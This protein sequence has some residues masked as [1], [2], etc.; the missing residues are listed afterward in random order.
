MEY[1]MLGRT[2][3]RV[4]AVGM[5]CEGFEGKSA[6]DC[7]ALLDCAMENGISFFDVYTSNPA[8]RQ[9]LGAA[10]RRYP[11]E[12][13]AVQG[14][15]CT[16]WKDGQYCRTRDIDEVKASFAALLTAM[17]LDWVDVGMIHYCDDPADFAAVLE[18]PVLRYAKEQQA[19]G[20]I[21]HI[22]L[23]THNTDVAL[24][25]VESGEIDVILFSVNPA[26]DM[27][28][29][30][31]DVELLFAEGT[32]DR[33]YT[34]IDPKREALYHAC[35]GAGV[36]LTV[37]KP[38][39]G[40]LLLDGRQSPFGRAMTP[41]QCLSYCLDRPAVASVM[42]GMGSEAEVLAAAAYADASAAERDYSDILAGAP[43]RSFSGRCM[44]CGHC[45][46]CTAGID[47][48]AVNRYFDL[49]EAEGFVPETVRDHYALLTHHADECVAC[50]ACMPN[51]PFG[52][53]IIGRMAQAAALFGE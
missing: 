47:I 15:L 12:R 9:H 43:R 48:A 13:F 8:V 33:V 31:D 49:A 44:Y 22:G 40:G 51:C 41:V 52:V 46:P 10:L 39:A 50:G 34:G 1:R 45:A 2:G 4:S 35:A 27:L 25:A 18:G 53:D 28:P 6:A 38:F 7:A 20:H 14:H 42:A 11:R 19:A 32:F 26:Y 29:P 36:A 24:A 30:T 37:M 21:R 17:E 16:T 3:L 23:S 5:G